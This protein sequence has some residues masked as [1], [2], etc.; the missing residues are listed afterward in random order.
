MSIH[1][2]TAE[3]VT[4]LHNRLEPFLDEKQSRIFAGIVADLY[5]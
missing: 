1:S 5:G 3:F 4:Q 2:E